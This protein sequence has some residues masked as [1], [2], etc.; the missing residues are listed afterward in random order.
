MSNR[1]AEKGSVPPRSRRAGSVSDRSAVPPISLSRNPDD[2]HVALHDQQSNQ[3][4]DVSPS[5]G[6]LRSR[7]AWT[8]AALSICATLALIAGASDEAPRVRIGSKS[9]TESVI[10]GDM[11]AQL[12]RGTGADVEHKKEIGGTLLLWKTLINGGLDAY[13]EY[14]GTIREEILAGKGIRDDDG[15]RAALAEHGI[16]MSQPLGFNNGYA[17]G[18]R[19][20]VADKLGIRKISDLREHPEL[21]FGFT[22]EFV[23]RADGWPRLRREYQLPQK[24]VR[25]L[26]HSLAYAG[27]RN[28]DIQVTD[29]YS[30]DA[31]IQLEKLRV[32]EDDRHVFPAYFA[33]ILYRAD[34]AERAPAA[35]EAMLK[36]EGRISEA[37]MIAMNTQANPKSNPR[38]PEERIAADFLASKGLITTENTVSEETLGGVLLAHTFEH[39]WLVL[40][41]L[42]A[43]IVTA[44]PL[45]IVAARKPAFGQVVLALAGVVQTIPSLAMLVFLLPWLGLGAKPAIVALFLYSL[46]PIM[47]NTYTG[48]HD[49]APS[50]RESAE[51]LGLPAFARLRLIEL[52]LASRAILAGI[53]T[54]AVIN[55]GT[56]TLG[57]FVGAGGYGQLIAKGLRLNS[58]S[59]ILEGAIPAALMA[60]LAQGLFELAERYVVPKGLRIESKP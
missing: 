41:S 18:M 37:E 53:K 50:L 27:L 49:L 55:I 26:E 46:L 58:Q 59:V 11:L 5:S 8:C 28:D 25:G 20:T 24:N 34:L 39:L 31:D 30:T 44:V 52:P 40:V 3:N 21:A 42:S 2:P 56:A 12:A 4:H 57:G 35:L 38:V 33:V 43:A 14:T 13:P 15:V 48:L 32:L 60:L 19:E 51:A 47:R 6:R 9:F 10:L 22:N 7:L 17:L 1:R 29:L 16:R 36:L 23:D 45:G 54:A